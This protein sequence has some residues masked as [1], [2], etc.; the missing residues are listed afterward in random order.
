M[1]VGHS[2]PMYPL[3]K[4]QGVGRELK[5]WALTPATD[6]GKYWHPLSLGHFLV[7]RGQERRTRVEE[8]N[9]LQSLKGEMLKKTPG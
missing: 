7:K 6:L 4:A 9:L 1:V 3:A 5:L 8:L 2:A